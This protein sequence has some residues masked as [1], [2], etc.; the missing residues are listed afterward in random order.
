MTETHSGI[1]LKNKDLEQFSQDAEGNYYYRIDN[2][3]V[4]VFLADD[5]KYYI[6]SGVVHEKSLLMTKFDQKKKS[7]GE[8]ELKDKKDKKAFFEGLKIKEKVLFD[9]TFPDE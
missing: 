8:K 1:E 6:M 2:V 5:G 7:D 3:H 4:D 9:V